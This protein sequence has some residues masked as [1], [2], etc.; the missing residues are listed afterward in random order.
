MTPVSQFRPAETVGTLRRCS[1]LLR[2]YGVRNCA[3][4]LVYDWRRTR[5]LLKRRFPPWAWGER[6]LADWLIPE[7]PAD[8]SAWVAFREE[9]GGRFLFAPGRPP[10]PPAEWLAGARQQAQALRRGEFRYFFAQCGRIGYPNPD[11]F[12]NPF[13]GQRDPGDRHWCDGGDFETERGDLK[14]IWEPSRFAWAYALARAYA[15]DPEPEYAETFWR[16]LDSWMEANPPQIGPNWMC[17]QEIAI[18]VMAL[19]FAVHAFWGSPATTP[20]RVAALLVLLAASAERIA[21]NIAYAR[22]QRSNHGVG[23]A[24]GLWTVGLL[25]PEFKEAGAWRTLAQ[26]VL[27]QEGKRNN[28][29]DGSYIQHSMNYQRF[30]LHDYLWCLR[31]GELNGAAWSARLRERLTRCHEF[32]YELQDA[33]TGRVPNYGPNDGALILPLNDC[34]YLD[35]RPV[36]DA[37]H[38]LVKRERLYPHGPWSEDLLWLFGPESLE[39]PI[40]PVPR[41][42]RDFL[43]GGYFTLRAERSWGMVRCHSYRSRPGQADM[44]HLD[45]WWQGLNVLRDSGSFS[46]FDPVEGWN[47][48]FASTSA[49]NTLTVAGRDQMVKGA[50]FQWFRLLRS[51]L[52]VHRCWGTLEFW[53]GEH[54]GYRR[55][56]C[57]AT[58]RRCVCRLGDEYWVIVDDLAGSGEEE[59]VL[60]WQLPDWPYTVRE[61]SVVL[62][63]PKGPCMLRLFST[64]KDWS[65]R[66]DRGQDAAG[67][68]EGWESLYYGVRQAAPVAVLRTRGPFPI[69]LVTLLALGNDCDVAEA[70]LQRALRWVPRGRSVACTV[71]LSSP[72]SG[73][74]PVTFLEKDECRCVL[75]S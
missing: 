28:W 14:Y 9:G 31:L 4:R 18:R 42:S 50:R 33:D 51:R 41:R 69:R 72:G 43:D 75:A 53:Q 63:T 20:Q 58:H 67:L 35:Y 47:E 11:W 22:S 55:L 30:I 10:R 57:R 7:T 26:E 1:S 2:Q 6:P 3:F 65:V 38:F 56:F 62:A 19:V 66:V 15:G 29:P 25:F 32:L 36:V 54:Y 49:H 16:L 48:Y 37:M 27:E 44:L 64:T 5:G 40:R 52:A 61:G 13:T 39:A 8:P 21:G 73:G 71:G 70:D 68:R 23:E 46:Y 60:R 59:I 45:L 24:A 74:H 34:E 17:G 12:L